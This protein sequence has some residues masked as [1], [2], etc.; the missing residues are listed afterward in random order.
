VDDVVID[1][2]R[3]PYYLWAT[4]PERVREVGCID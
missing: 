4:Q 3:R 1:D 2:R